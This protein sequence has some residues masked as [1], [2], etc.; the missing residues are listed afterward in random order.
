MATVIPDPSAKVVYGV[1]KD[2]YEALVAERDRLRAAF[3]AA[4]AYIHNSQDNGAESQ[5]RYT[6]WIEARKKVDAWRLPKGDI[7]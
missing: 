3:N 4:Y 1:S 6:A 7:P 5:A 2:E